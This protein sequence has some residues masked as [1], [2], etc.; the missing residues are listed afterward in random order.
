MIL[1]GQRLIP[2]TD[3]YLLDSTLV[4][5]HITA[6]ASQ[7]SRKIEDEGLFKDLGIFF[8]FFFDTLYCFLFLLVQESYLLKK[9]RGFEE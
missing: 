1:T 2:T 3:A 9:K 7:V 5:S 6:L 8:V 4:Y